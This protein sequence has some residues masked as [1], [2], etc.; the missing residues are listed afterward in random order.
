MQLKYYSYAILP[1]M[2]GKRHEGSSGATEESATRQEPFEPF[3]TQ[4]IFGDMGYLMDRGLKEPA[5]IRKLPA[6]DVVTNVRNNLDR[7][8]GLV[9]HLAH[10][11][12]DGLTPHPELEFIGA[13]LTKLARG[14]A[15]AANPYL[16]AGHVVEGECVEEYEE[17]L[18][19]PPVH[20]IN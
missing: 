7:A 20:Q 3:D 19:I 15:V 4:R 13:A 8:G 1:I 11:K 12:G 18:P 14:E 17:P 10:E 9:D 2:F 5:Y 6:S 16:H